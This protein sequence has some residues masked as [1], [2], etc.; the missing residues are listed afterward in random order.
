MFLMAQPKGAL[1]L[2]NSRWAVDI[3]KGKDV[4]QSRATIKPRS[5]SL[6][7][8]WDEERARR[9]PLIVESFEGLVG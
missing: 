5:G 6:G 3:W 7:F 4:V 8:S 1:T 9:F 2:G